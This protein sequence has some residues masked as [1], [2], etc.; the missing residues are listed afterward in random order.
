MGTFQWAPPDAA[1]E[2]RPSEPPLSARGRRRLAGPR[3][4]QRAVWSAFGE[5]GVLALLKLASSIPG[6]RI[7]LSHAHACQSERP[8][9]A[10]GTVV[11]GSLTLSPA[12]AEGTPASAPF[13][14]R[15]AAAWWGGGGVGRSSEAQSNFSFKTTARFPPSETLT[16]SA[17]PPVTSSEGAERFPEQ[18]TPP[19]AAIAV[20]RKTQLKSRSSSLPESLWMASWALLAL[21]PSNQSQLLPPNATSC[22][23]DAGRPGTCCTGCCPPSSSRLLLRA[24]GQPLRAVRLPPAPARLSAAEIYLANLAAS[25][26]VFVLGLPFWAENIWNQF[27]WPFGAALCRV[28]NGV[29]KA[30]L[31]ISIF[32]VVA[33]SRDRYCALVHPMAS[34]RRRRR[35]LAQVTCLLIWAVGGLLS[36]PTFL[37]RSVKVVPDLNVSAC[38]LRLPHQAWHFARMVELNVVG[39]LLPLAPSSSSTTTSWPPC[40]GGPRSWGARCG[41]PGEGK[42]TA[43]ILTLVAAF[44][45]CWAPYHFFAFLE[46]L[47]QWANFFAFINSCL[48]PVIYVFVGQL[49]RTQVWELYKKCAPGSLAAMSSSQRKEIPQLFWRN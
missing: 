26:L 13:V 1:A 36:V 43:L 4:C 6:D 46:F 34:R 20:R 5:R 22:E 12:P 17:T 2:P 8:S 39:F 28:V 18:T 31:F 33:I 32:L 40:A 7:V 35:R 21:Q 44:L 49:F 24:A 11:T 25:D 47:V 41:G 3:G 14:G 37:L 15:V 10:L 30:N 29:I 48:N 42:P 16:F 45:V 23:D 19:E 9:V 27:H 38:V